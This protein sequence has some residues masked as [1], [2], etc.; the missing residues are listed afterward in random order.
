VNEL[1]DEVALAK[2]G[3][4]FAALEDRYDRN[5]DDEELLKKIVA[6]RTLYPQRISEAEPRQATGY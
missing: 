4:T 6:V 3:E 1:R 2:F 5:P